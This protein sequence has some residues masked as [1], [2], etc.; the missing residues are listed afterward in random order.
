MA[1]EMLRYGFDFKP[2]I[3]EL[4]KQQAAAQ[5]GLMDYVADRVIAAGGMCD[6]I[7]FMTAFW[8][9]AVTPDINWSDAFENKK[10]MAPKITAEAA[11][12]F[13]V[14]KQVEL[15]AGCVYG[16]KGTQSMAGDEADH[17]G[18]IL[19]DSS[20]VAVRSLRYMISPSSRYDSLSD[21]TG[22]IGFSAVHFERDADR[23]KHYKHGHFPLVTVKRSR[24]VAESKIIGD[25]T[26]LLIGETSIRGCLGRANTHYRHD[27]ELEIAM[28]RLRRAAERYNLAQV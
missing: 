27:D 19:S 17:L 8:G 4:R 6:D 16:W 9:G 18:A 3:D 26:E 15:S 28:R 21:Y 10:L 1:G 5:A 25:P 23:K 13:G 20:D 22:T 14:V 24:G 11:A 12:L 2:E 7:L